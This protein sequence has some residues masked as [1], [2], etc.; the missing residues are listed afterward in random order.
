MFLIK[1]LLAVVLGP[2]ILYGLY[3]NYMWMYR[4]TNHL[5][6][7]IGAVVTLVILCFPLEMGWGSTAEYPL[8]A[9]A[10]LAY[11]AIG[12]LRAFYQ[13]TGWLQRNYSH[14]LG[15]L[16]SVLGVIGLVLGLVKGSIIAG[17]ALGVVA[18]VG[19]AFLYLKIAG[20]PRQAAPAPAETPTQQ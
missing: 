17:L 2:F 11:A 9:A 3:L 13:F 18:F 16:S 7:S 8:L 4:H 15:V 5:L 19:T 6:A 20:P 1:D 10:G 14:T 12:A